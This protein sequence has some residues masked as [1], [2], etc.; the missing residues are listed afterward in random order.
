MDS[1][2]RSGALVATGLLSALTLTACGGDS[3]SARPDPDLGPASTG[4]APPVG[5]G[6]DTA[7]AA[8]DIAALQGSWT[9]TSGGEPV[10]LSVTSG[11]VALAA[12]PHLCQGEVKDRGAVVFTLECL[13]GDTDRTRGTVG[14]NDG[15]KL[16]VAW[17]GGTEDPLTKTDPGGS[18]PSGPPSP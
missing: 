6:E 9:G 8:P 4:S 1:L 3:P 15:R 18:T 10:A 12:G 5:G 16:V 14:S 11:K 7:T 13:D 2:Q 17:D